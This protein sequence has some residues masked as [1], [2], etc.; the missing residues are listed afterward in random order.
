MFSEYKTPIPVIL[1]VVFI[2]FLIV[3]LHGVVPAA[4]QSYPFQ[5][6]PDTPVYLQNFAHVEKGCNWMGVAGQVFDATGQPIERMVVRV[7]GVLGNQAV[8]ALGLTSLATAYGP[9]GFEIELAQQ[10]LNSSG[11][12]SIALYD[13]QG[14]QVSARIP[15]NTFSDCSKNLVIVNFIQ[16]GSPVTPTLTPTGTVSGLTVNGTVALQGRPATPHPSWVISLR[17]DLIAPGQSE[18]TTTFTTTTDENGQ[19]G[20]NN[21]P[22]GSYRIGI[23]AENSLRALTPLTTLQIGSNQLPV[24]ALKLG[25]ANNDNFI[26]AADFSILAGA[27]GNCLGTTGYVAKADFNNDKCVTAADFSILSGNYGLQGD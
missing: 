1:R 3:V 11:F 20:I 23:K 22:A 4:G 25:D 24:V 16:T 12:L 17:L 7:E 9:G 15:F 27:F 10:T 14:Q 6:Q 2:A 18:A 19:F 8:D 5:V 13:L 21:P 26:S